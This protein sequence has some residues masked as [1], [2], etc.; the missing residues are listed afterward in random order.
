MTGG[1]SRN[2]DLN[3]FYDV[4]FPCPTLRQIALTSSSRPV[5]SHG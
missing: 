3:I 5:I 2:A 4:S 1:D